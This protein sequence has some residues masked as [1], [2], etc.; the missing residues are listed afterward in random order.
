MQVKVFINESLAGAL[1]QARD[2]LGPDA[3]IISRDRVCNEQ[4]EKVW[5]IHAAVELPAKQSGEASVHPAGINQ[6][7]VRLEHLVTS[8]ESQQ[9]AGLRDQ[10]TT[11]QQ[12]HAFDSLL[13]G[14]VHPS[15]AIETAQLMCSNQLDQ[16]PFLQWANRLEATQSCQTVAFVGTTGAGKTTLLCKLASW[17]KRRHNSRMAFITTDHD[18]IGGQAVL[19]Q[20]AD[21]LDAEFHEVRELSET[22]QF[23][24]ARRENLDYIFVDTKGFGAEEATTS[25]LEKVLNILCCDRCMLVMPVTIDEIDAG[26]VY[27]RLRH[28]PLSELAVTKLD[29]GVRP[30]KAI[31]FAANFNLPFSYCSSGASVSEGLGWLSPDALSSML[32]KSWNESM[33]RSLIYA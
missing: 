29:E 25:F 11:A 33:V 13:R 19:R 5:H 27:E 15:F 8:I 9:H 28:L 20:V 12:R 22:E 16:A 18:R 10:L 32:T 23:V 2:E 21:I 17:F 31:N 6:A 7:L 4:G 3:L 30:A 24:A 26:C 14:G 1:A